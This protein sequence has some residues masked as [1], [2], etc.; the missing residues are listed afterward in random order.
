[1]FYVKTCEVGGRRLGAHEYS[2]GGDGLVSETY[3]KGFARELLMVVTSTHSF[4]LYYTLYKQGV[5]L[6]KLRR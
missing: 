4:S 6:W 3:L 2:V 5:G 1:M